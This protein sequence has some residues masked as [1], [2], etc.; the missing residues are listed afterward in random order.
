VPV[1]QLVQRFDR[2]APIGGHLLPVL[3]RVAQLVEPR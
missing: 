2:G 1:V 3:G